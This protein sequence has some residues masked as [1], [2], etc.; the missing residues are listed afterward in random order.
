MQI[1]SDAKFIIGVLIATV[2]VIGGG[3]YMT[4]KKSSSPTNKIVPE[5]LLQHLVREDVP[6][7]GSANAKVSVVEFADFQ[8]PACGVLH[9]VL[10][11]I[12]KQY[13]DKSVRFVFRQFPL[14]QHENAI[15]AAKASLAALA[16]GKF[17]EYQ[18]MLFEHQ[19]NLKQ[20]DLEA[21]AKQ[22]EM[23]MDTFTATMATTSISDTIQRDR[24]DGDTLGVRSTPTIFIN[25]IQYTGKYSLEDISAVIDSELNK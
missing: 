11:E 1:T 13:A 14:P 21:Y 2:L 16:Q 15:P 12:K 7:I 10:K 24:T 8:C 3:A 5:H 6:V 25:N 17:W 22:L 20:E 19:T 4:S 9:Q 18:D 23:N